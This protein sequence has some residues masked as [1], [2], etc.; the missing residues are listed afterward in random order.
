MPRLLRP[1]MRM[2]TEALFLEAIVIH[3]PRCL[4]AGQLDPFVFTYCGTVRAPRPSLPT[5]TPGALD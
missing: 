1:L 4:A 5:S 3:S 2:T